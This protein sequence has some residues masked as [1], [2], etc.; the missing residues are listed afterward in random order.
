M[1]SLLIELFEK[2]KVSKVFARDF[3]KYCEKSIEANTFLTLGQESE[4]LRGYDE[5]LKH[6]I[7]AIDI[8][9]SDE[10]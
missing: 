5:V 7:K 1:S 6:L 4:Y 10:K 9:L 8:Y 3:K 2:H